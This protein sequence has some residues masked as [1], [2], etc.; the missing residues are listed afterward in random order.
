[1]EIFNSP[2]LE[3]SELYSREAQEGK[4]DGD[5]PELYQKAPLD[6]ASRRLGVVLSNAGDTCLPSIGTHRALSSPQPSALNL[7]DPTELW[8]L[9]V[10]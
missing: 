8:F 9:L 5:K 2:K 1:M 4:V 3:D 7:C 10:C 6:G